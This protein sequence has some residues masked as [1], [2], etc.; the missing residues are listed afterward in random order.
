MHEVGN[1]KMAMDICAKM[2]YNKLKE[3]TV[4]RWAPGPDRRQTT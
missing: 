4:S 3:L 1:G 2:K